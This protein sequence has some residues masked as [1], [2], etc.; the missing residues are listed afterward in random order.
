MPRFFPPTNV[1]ASSHRLRNE[2][3]RTVSTGES[4]WVLNEI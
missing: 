4:L 3:C 2:I 1:Q